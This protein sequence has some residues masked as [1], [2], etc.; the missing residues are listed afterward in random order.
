MVLMILGAILVTVLGIKSLGG[1]TELKKRLLAFVNTKKLS[2]NETI[3]TNLRHY[4]ELQLTLHEINTIIDGIAQG[5]SGDLLT[6]N[7]QQALF[8]L[9]SIT[10]EITTETL[11][12]NIFG[13]F[14]IG[15]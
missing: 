5:V 1:I 7:I 8:H 9:G 12:G 10:G 3:V 13:K 14:C 6:I 4:N 11:L 15:K 2:S